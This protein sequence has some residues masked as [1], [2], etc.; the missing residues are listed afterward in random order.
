MIRYK[1][2]SSV[3][4]LLLVAVLPLVAAADMG[5]QMKRYAER[6]PKT[7]DSRSRLKKANEFFAFLYAAQYIDEPIVFPASSHMDSV[8]VNVYYYIAEWYYG[9]GNYRRT[10][11][12]CMHATNCF[13]EVDDVSKSD[14]YALLGAAY[15]RMSEYDNAIEA[16]NKSYELDKSFGDPDRLSSSLNSI[17][18]AFVAAGRPEEAEKYILEAIEINSTTRNLAR[19]AVLYGT[20]SEIYRTMGKGH[21][22]LTYAREALEI[23]RQ[24]GDSAHM[25]VRLSQMANA[26]LV[27]GKTRDA[28][29]SLQSAI[30]L[31]QA[32]GNK[33][34]LGIC[35]NQMGDILSAEGEDVEAAEYYRQAAE[36]FLAQGDIY[37]ESHAREGLYKS[38]KMDAPGEAMMHLERAKMLH[39]SIYQTKTG[40]ALSRY[41]AM[42][43][44]DILQIEKKRVEREKRTILIISLIIAVALILVIATGFYYARHRERRAEQDFRKN[45]TSLEDKYNE[46][47]RLYQNV[48]AERML[49]GKDITDDDRYFL[50]KLAAVIGTLSEQGISDVGTIADEMHVSVTTLRRRLAT[51]LS[52][53]PQTYILRVRM[54][55]A[56]HLLHEYRDITVSEVA[57]RCGYSQPANFTRAFYRYYG[58]NP[59]EARVQKTETNPKTV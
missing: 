20:A 6:Y 24:R 14:V 10:V 57:E 43:Y 23:D 45:V 58:I 33:H 46:V 7:A 18:S 25:G 40:E 12:Y 29:R 9:E 3:V 22:S 35:Q 27:L 11:D 47:Q 52:E 55:K 15:F 31:L 51:I 13:G 32:A 39:D 50:T 26:Q 2:L 53:T 59:T 28:K 49:V 34:S 8:D 56:K 21:K 1:R 37:N 5:V 54:E 17:A 4:F 41:N 30:P 42:Y 44:N 16:L 36:I 38:L 48:V 19:R